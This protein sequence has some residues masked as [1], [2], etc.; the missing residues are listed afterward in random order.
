MYIYGINH[1]D[2]NRCSHNNIKSLGER[3]LAIFKTSHTH[4]RAQG[5]TLKAGVGVYYIHNSRLYCTPLQDEQTS[6][7]PGRISNIPNI[8]KI[9]DLEAQLT[10]KG[11]SKC[12][13]AIQEMSE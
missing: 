6:R 2:N 3:G 13:S 5:V 12:S 10:Q 4:M 11:E 7:L 9:D 1:Y 8:G